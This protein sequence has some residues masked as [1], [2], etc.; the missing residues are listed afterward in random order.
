MIENYPKV[1]GSQLYNLGFDIIIHSS[2]NVY[3]FGKKPQ[4]VA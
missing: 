4:Q 3:D 2:S 1:N